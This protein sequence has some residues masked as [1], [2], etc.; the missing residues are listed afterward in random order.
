MRKRTLLIL[1]TFAWV[2]PVSAHGAGG[3]WQPTAHSKADCPAARARAEA[4]ARH[5]DASTSA[6]AIAAPVDLPGEGSVFGMGRS[7]VL[8]P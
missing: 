2:G 8:M 7:S 3:A 6:R 5:Q 4:A 1:A